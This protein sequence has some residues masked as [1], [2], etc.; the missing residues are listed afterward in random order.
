M[1]PTFIFYIFSFAGGIGMSK[2]VLQ[3]LKSSVT[4]LIKIFLSLKKLHKVF[5]Q[6]CVLNCEF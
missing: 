6:I 3:I 1:Q 4:A 5:A 2:D